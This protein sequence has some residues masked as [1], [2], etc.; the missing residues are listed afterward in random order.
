MACGNVFTASRMSLSSGESNDTLGYVSH[1]FQ[2]SPLGQ[3]LSLPGC[4]GLV[5]VLR[6]CV[7]GGVCAR[8][9]VQPVA[10]RRCG[11]TAVVPDCRSDSC[12]ESGHCG[13]AGN[14][15]L[16]EDERRGPAG[17]RAKARGDA[18]L[19]LLRPGRAD[20]NPHPFSHG[21]KYTAQMGRNHSPAFRASGP[22][23]QCAFEWHL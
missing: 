4:F 22:H 17:S 2:A 10:R 20:G 12:G 6:H 1:A 8:D 23:V 14:G 9:D 13:V 19:E 18:R 7:R 5:V 16:R 3:E 11:E 21:H 15:R